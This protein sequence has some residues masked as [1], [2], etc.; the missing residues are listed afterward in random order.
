MHA[1]MAI[2]VYAASGDGDLEAFLGLFDRL[3]AYFAE[4][5]G[6]ATS[7]EEH[8]SRHPSD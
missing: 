6:A 8:P 5:I 1:R 7:S 4:V 3:D 2:A